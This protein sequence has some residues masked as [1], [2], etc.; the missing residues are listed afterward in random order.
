MLKLP[1]YMDH[2]ATTPLDPEV[3]KMMVDC[4]QHTIGN[5]ASRN[6]VFGWEAEKRVEE[7]RDV[8]ARLIGAQPK[9]IVFTSGATESNNLAIR[10]AALMYRSK[11]N[12]V[13][14]QPTEHKAV[15]EPCARLQREG[16]RVTVL[17]VDSYGRVN[18]EEVRR[19]IT[20]QTILISIMAANNEVG[21]IQPIAEIGR[22]A[23]AAGVL[24]HTD[25]AQAVGKIPI[26]VERMGIDLM[27]ITAHKMYG[28]KGVGALYVRQK[29]PR[30]RLTPLL[31]GGG[32]ERGLRP[33]TLNVAGIVG[34]ASACE[35]AGRCMTEE[36]ERLRGLRERLYRAITADLDHVYLNGH[37]TE[38]LPGN[39]HVSFAYTEADAI[40]M[41]LKD[42]AVSSGSACTSAVLEPSHVLRA[43]GVR[44]ERA[45]G[46]VRFGLGR[47]NTEEEIDY[48]HR[49]VV[50]VV[51]RLRQTS[52]VYAAMRVSA[53]G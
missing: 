34:L 32:H 21:T 19:A 11:G 15:L 22:I 1:I 42:I 6:H 26:D 41:G 23:K 16:F 52:P 43:I 8:I 9:D 37:P 28:P 40:L 4:Y 30:V 13:I 47:F 5:A 29:N 36:S 48:T 14:T 2:H 12:H 33:G 45:A 25:A 51:R 31:D 7:A 46:A 35:I 3:L 20:D 10:G 24:F 44:E 17:E 49:K 27:S 38:R 39:L 50:D 53:K 18:P